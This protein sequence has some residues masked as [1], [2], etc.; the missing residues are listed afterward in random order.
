M[1]T[2]LAGR[3]EGFVWLWA[4]RGFVWLWASSKQPPSWLVDRRERRGV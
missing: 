2:C 1:D 3:R 4:S